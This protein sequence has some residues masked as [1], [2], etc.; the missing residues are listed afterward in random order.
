M[1]YIEAQVTAG[2]GDPARFTIKA[3]AGSRM[4]F[5]DGDWVIDL[6]GR[7]AAKDPRGVP[8]LYAHDWNDQMGHASTVRID[9]DGVW[10]DGVAS[11]PTDR[12]R[13]WVESAR[14]G[15]PWQASLGFLIRGA[16]EV[17]EGEEIEVNGRTERGPVKIATDI[18]VWECSVV[19]FGADD[20]TETKITAGTSPAALKRIEGKSMTV[21]NI[22]KT[23]AGD[24]EKLRAAR[25]A[26]TARLDALQ[27][28]AD[29]YHDNAYLAQA[30]AEGWTPDR[31]EL[32]TLRHARAAVPAPCPQAP[33]EPSRVAAAAFLRAAGAQVSD[34]VFTAAEREAADRLKGSD[35]R[36]IFEAAAG[37]TP[38][39]SQR[40]DARAWVQAA[41]STYNLGGALS[42]TANAIL[43]ESLSAYERRWAPFFKFTS[44][45]DFR[46]V[47]RFRID[48]AF[49]FTET[50]PAEELEHGTQSEI[51]W[52]IQAKTYGR[53]YVLPYQAIVNGEAIG[54]FTDIMR[55]IAYGAESALNR[56]CW[57]LV[58]DPGTA[59]DGTAYYSAAHGSLLTS[60][61]FSLDNLAAAVAAFATRK[62]KAEAEPAGVEPR[63]LVVPP[64]L[65]AAARQVV[66]ST[67]LNNGATATTGANYNPM[68]GIV[69]V[70]TA[71]QLEFT[72]FANYSATTWY[73]FAAPTA[74]A[75]FE[76]AFLRGQ[77]SPTLRSSELEI[78]RLGIGFDGHIDFGVCAEDWR[79][80][81]KVTA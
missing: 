1:K 42:S 53:Q 18:E 59:V 21:N 25:A 2:Q 74:C 3:N 48:S 62:K 78:G 16:L 13:E 79:G 6:D 8:I 50:A 32:E 70:I 57:G 49:E 81:L 72:D 54:V 61:A 35:F 43:L 29:K 4:T 28:L 69:D 52:E 65:S 33:T 24:V 66:N 15:F 30:Q 9:A 5:E 7:V 58:M 11:V 23:I 68:A 34:R 63:F 22:D 71:P 77:Q 75:A 46:K 41:A 14:L 73:L 26:E 38:T 76:I 19:T 47:E 17:P 67:W 56:A 55:Q 40:T 80:A 12:S 27:A 20:K 45:P 31:F 60:K 39:T 36:G 37:F 10:L 51:S 44:V 64:S